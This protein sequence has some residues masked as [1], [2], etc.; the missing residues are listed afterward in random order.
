MAVVADI[1]LES[2]DLSEFSGTVTD[3]GDLSV[4]QAAALA[5]S[6]YGLQCVIDDTTA[7]YGYVLLGS[8]NTSGLFVIGFMW[9]RTASRCRTATSRN[10]PW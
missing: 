10:I 3:G 1:D 2:G 5:G 6:E 9:T 8:P 4:T 7:V